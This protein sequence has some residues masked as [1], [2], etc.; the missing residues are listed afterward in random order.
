VGIIPGGLLIVSAFC[1][2]GC[3]GDEESRAILGLGLALAGFAGGAAL[4]ITGA[5]SLLHGEGE[6]WPTAGGA[7]LGTLAGTLLGLALAS[8]LDEAA[9]VPFLAGPVI[10]GMI[11]YELSH[12]NAIA[13][14]HRNPALTP[15]V[16]PMAT[17]S[18]HGGV[19]GGLVGRF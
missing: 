18:P 14:R 3:S 19:I 16:M 13:R 2:D 10:G 7:A 9:L 1:T 4:G 12:S 6:Y 5:G 15:R 8:T 17:V 11:A